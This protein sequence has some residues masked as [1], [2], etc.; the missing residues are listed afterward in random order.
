MFLF[1][2]LGFFRVC[3]RAHAFCMCTQVRIHTTN[4]RTQAY[5]CA[6]ILMHRNPNL[7]FLLLFLY[8]FY[9]ICFYFDLLIWFGWPGT[10]PRIQARFP[11]LPRRVFPS[12]LFHLVSHQWGIILCEILIFQTETLI[13]IR[14]HNLHPI[15]L[16]Y[17]DSFDEESPNLEG[18]D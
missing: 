6:H 2:G 8:F 17:H 7:S 13:H 1:S 12:L 9:I 18:Y 16:I 4:L 3:L 14:I 11:N 10:Y 5:V 15:A